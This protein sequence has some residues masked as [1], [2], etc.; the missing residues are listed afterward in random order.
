MIRNA[1]PGGLRSSMLPVGQGGI[2]VGLRVVFHYSP[3]YDFYSVKI[4]APVCSLALSW[5]VAE[6][7]SRSYWASIPQ[8]SI[9][10]G[11]QGRN[12]F[13]LWNG[14]R[15]GDLR[16]SKQAAL[17]TAPG[18][19]SQIEVVIEGELSPYSMYTLR[20]ADWKPLTWYHSFSMIFNIFVVG[21]LTRI[22][23]SSQS[24]KGLTLT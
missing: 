10:N 9:F 7:H 4:Q 22:S 19:L 2:P 13:F 21:L 17:T 24:Q 3:G 6:Y 12:I 1:I 20:A 23:R 11:E 16:L 8:Y 18:P 15:T 5:T 14:G